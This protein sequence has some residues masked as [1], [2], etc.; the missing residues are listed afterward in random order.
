M[1][2]PAPAFRGGRVGLL[3]NAS[4]LAGSLRATRGLEFAAAPLPAH[5]GIH[6][7]YASY[8][9]NALVNGRAGARREAAAKFMQYVTSPEAMAIWAAATGELPARP[10][11]EAQAAVE[12]DAVLAPF[13][14]GL[15]GAYATDFVDE[16]A[17]RAVFVEML[18]R[19]LLKGQRPLDAVMEAAAAEQAIIT[20]YYKT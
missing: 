12:R 20:S 8:W 6:A 16:D 18:D 14:R 13:G 5:N 4:F 2:E 19:V 1:T 11:P 15:E 7:N 9:V 10:S 17:Q 3:V